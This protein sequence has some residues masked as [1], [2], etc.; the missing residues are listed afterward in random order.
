MLIALVLSAMACGGGGGGGGGTPPPTPGNPLPAITSISPT[1]TRAGGSGLTLDVT[2]SGFIPTSVVRWNGSDRETRFQSIFS[3]I[4]FILASDIAAEG[5]AQVTVFNPPPGGGT[6][7]AVP[8]TITPAVNPVPVLTS[9][10]PSTVFAGGAIFIL[11]VNGA[12]F[13]HSSTVQL[14]GNY[15][16]TT[17]V[18]FTQLQTRID[19]FDINLPTTFRVTVENFPPGGGTSNALDLLVV[20]GPPPAGEIERVSLAN[21]GRQASSSSL[22]PSITPD[23]RFVAF[24]SEAYNLVIGDTNTWSDVFVRDTCTGAPPGCTP[25]TVRVSVASDGTEGNAGSA[26][27]SISADGRFVAF[28]SGSTNLVPGDT[29]GQGGIFWHDRDADRN[30]V[31]DEPGGIATVRVS[32]SS[33]GAEANSR[34][35]YP[36][37]S[38][39]GRFVAFQS[40]ADNLVPGDT[41]GVVDVFVRDTCTGAPLGC[42]PTTER[43]S[44]SSNGLQASCSLAGLTGCYSVEP[45]ISADG[46][47]IAFTSLADNLV[48]GDT[49]LVEDVFVRDTCTGAP[50]GCTP[51][52][53][54]VSLASDGSEGKLGGRV[55]TISADGR[56]V[57]FVSDFLVP[58]DTN[59]QQD[60]FVRDTCT[61]APV[62]CTPTTV[63]ASVASDG[64]QANDGSYEPAISPDGRFVAFLSPAS[65]LAPADTNEELDVFIHDTCLGAPAGCTSATVR[66]SVANDGTQGGDSGF[67]SRPEVRLS[68]NGRFAAFASD[69]DNLVPGDTNRARDI[70]RARSGF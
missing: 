35:F 17:F 42:I 40:F 18:S 9:L 14:N 63:L 30:G 16:S 8:F 48:P 50:P 11:T 1:G 65:N 7:N 70:F 32:V 33:S 38:A 22:S 3:L 24:T 28:V 49:N 37:I 52:T 54:R 39:D 64:T 68:R 21:D 41:N 56:F 62:G 19:S 44:V 60:I 6:S 55:A 20:P 4:A 51:S 47:F 36:S 45:S 26:G 12:N 59:L 46:R 67:R 57:A 31:F 27:V 13:V 23:G 10:S 29:N 58:G 25:S 15:R 34:S 43:V 5:T 69:A 61:G 66:V 2:G 53:V